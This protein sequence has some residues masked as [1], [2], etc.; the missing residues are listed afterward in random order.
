MDKVNKLSQPAKDIIKTI[1]H[2]PINQKD[3]ITLL[4]DTPLN[5]QRCLNI[6]RPAVLWQYYGANIDVIHQSSKL[7]RRYIYEYRNGTSLVGMDPYN[8]VTRRMTNEM[9][10]IVT[11]KTKSFWILSLQIWVRNPIIAQLSCITLV[12]TSSQIYL[13]E[14]I[15]ILYILQQM[16]DLLQKRI[17]K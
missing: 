16:V 12:L 10:Y 17:L 4:R 7:I 9:E 14:C 5:N 13:W 11:D 1:I 15:V 8:F 2:S 6:L 3:G